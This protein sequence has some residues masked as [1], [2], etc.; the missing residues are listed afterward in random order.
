[1]NFIYILKH[2]R[3]KEWVKKSEMGR[4]ASRVPNQLWHNVC[5]IKKAKLE[6]KLVPNQL[7]HNVCEIKKEEP[8]DRK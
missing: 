3:G 5:E 4:I 2:L 6:T 1:M 7:Q 8:D